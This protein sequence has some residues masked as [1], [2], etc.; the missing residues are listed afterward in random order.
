[1]L[2]GGK[3]T[4]N[5]VGERGTTAGGDTAVS[6]FMPAEVTA[7]WTVSLVFRAGLRPLVIPR[8]EQVYA[9]TIPTNA[10]SLMPPPGSKLPGRSL[11]AGT[12]TTQ[13]TKISVLESPCPEGWVLHFHHDILVSLAPKDRSILLLW[14]LDFNSRLLQTT[15][16]FYQ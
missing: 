1:M 15:Q 10:T 2:R 14:Y 3:E 13:T 6:S 9:E 7:Y 8:W 4:R 16:A 12:Y 5:T 11:W